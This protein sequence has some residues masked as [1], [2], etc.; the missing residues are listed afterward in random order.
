MLSKKSI[1][2]D[3]QIIFH[4]FCQGSGGGGQ[5]GT[6]YITSELIQQHSVKKF[7]TIRRVLKLLNNESSTEHPLIIISTRIQTTLYPYRCFETCLTYFTCGQ[8]LLLKVHVKFLLS[9]WYFSS[10]AQPFPSF[11]LWC[12]HNQGIFANH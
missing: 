10:L 4:S 12:Q 2:A 11:N 6:N 5:G 9:C 1:L 8:F 3:F 7:L